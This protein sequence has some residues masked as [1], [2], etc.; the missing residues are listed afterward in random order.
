ML[1]LFEAQ[2]VRFAI[3]FAAYRASLGGFSSLMSDK[4]GTVLP[5]RTLAT[6]I[7]G[8]YEIRDMASSAVRAITY[9]RHL[10]VCPDQTCGLNAGIKRNEKRMETLEKVYKSLLGERE[11][12]ML[13]PP[14]LGYPLCGKC[15]KT[16]GATHAPWGSVCW[17]K[18]TQLFDVSD[19]WDEL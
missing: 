6:T 3:P 9:G 15:T 17:E 1:N 12:G 19:S 14:S 13:A 16:I 2:N 7:H 4:P 5:R 18:L 10:G 11:G 8:M